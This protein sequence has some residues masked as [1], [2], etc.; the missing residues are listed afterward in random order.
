MAL[1][2]A[3]VH[4]PDEDKYEKWITC[5]STDVLIREAAGRK[6]IKLAQKCVEA[7]SPV[8]AKFGCGMIAGVG[9]IPCFLQVSSMSNGSGLGASL[10]VADEQTEETMHHLKCTGEDAK[11]LAAA[12][13]LDFED[14]NFLYRDKDEATK[15]LFF[16]VENAANGKKRDQHIVS[17]STLRSLVESGVTSFPGGCE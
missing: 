16:L 11:K 13:A 6:G 15:R 3:L 12:F 7:A 10:V 1:A 14:A 8:L 2:L 5:A 17:L 9:D 4:S